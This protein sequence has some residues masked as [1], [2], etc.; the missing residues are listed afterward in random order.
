MKERGKEME[1]DGKKRLLLRIYIYVHMCYRK[2]ECI[3]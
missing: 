3:R 2:N 1:R